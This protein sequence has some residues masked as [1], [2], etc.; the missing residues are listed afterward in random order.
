MIDL[1]II[2]PAYNEGSK[3]GQNLRKLEAFLQSRHYGKVEIV[4]MMQ[5]DDNSGGREA[6]AIVDKKYSNLRVINLGERA[7]KGGAVKAGMLKTSGRYRMFMDADL[8]T[9]LTHLDDVYSLMQ[10]QGDV[11]I[12]ARDLVRIHKGILRKLISK[13]ANIFA[14]AI[15]FLHV[16]D[17]QCGFKVFSKNAVNDI[18]PRLTINGWAFDLE[19][20]VLAKKFGYNIEQFDAQDWKDPKTH[21]LVGDSPLKAMVQSLLDAF[22]IR[23]NLIAHKYK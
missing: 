15:L 13:A 2:I 23:W 19:I 9:P 1:S 21:G 3:L 14:Q 12:A 18:F 11:G 7:G 10:K 16:K 22:K 4:V 20:L 17:T 8:A 6:A 5:S